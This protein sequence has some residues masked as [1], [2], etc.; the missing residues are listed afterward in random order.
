MKLSPIVYQ[1][2]IISLK[3][4]V[5]IIDSKGVHFYNCD[6]TTEVISKNINFENKIENE[7]ICIKQYLKEYGEYILILVFDIIYFLESD[8]TKINSI[9]IPEISN[10]DCYSL[11]PYKKENNSLYY[12]IAYII[13]ENLILKKFKFDI[14]SFLNQIIMI[15]NIKINEYYNYKKFHFLN[16]LFLKEHSDFDTLSCF[17]YNF[18]Q[19]EVISRSFDINTNLEIK[20]YSKSYYNFKTNIPNPIISTFTNNKKQNSLVF[21]INNDIYWMNYAN[22]NLLSKPKKIVKNYSDGIRLLYTKKNQTHEFVFISSTFDKLLLAFNNN[23]ILL[24]QIFLN[25]KENKCIYSSFNS[26]HKKTNNS[27][28]KMGI[29]TDS[30]I[31]KNIKFKKNRRILNDINDNEKINENNNNNHNRDLG[32]NSNPPPSPGKDDGKNKDRNDTPP[33]DMD[34][35]KFNETEREMNNKFELGE[36]EQILRA[37]YNL[38]DN[39]TLIINE[40]NNNNGRGRRGPMSFE[41]YEPINNTKLNLSLCNN[42]RFRVDKPVNI[43][44]E[45]LY[46]YDTNSNYYNDICFAY[47]SENGTDVILVDRR[48]EYIQNNMSLCERNCDYEGYDK[49]SKNA[50]CDCE[51]VAENTNSDT[52]PIHKKLAD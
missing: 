45:N 25:S 20:R 17:I 18:N 19:A 2:N 31:F 23:F 14:N 1:I 46:K 7:K 9:S 11:I 40:I 32:D 26:S 39:I 21:L 41:V 49:D 34:S 52:T 5:I 16:C 35:T 42:T 47:T 27:V 51:I 36:C 24:N 13:K 50:K 10:A 48:K 12:I 8:G 28:I 33:Q 30:N 37:H 43:D 44:E 6:L 15:N 38:D 3:K 4:D 29:P 22:D